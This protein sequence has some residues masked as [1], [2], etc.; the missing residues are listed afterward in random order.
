MK[1]VLSVRQS[2]R[3][4]NKVT[5]MKWNGILQHTDVIAD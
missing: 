5:I 2:V 4:Q 1:L 3:G